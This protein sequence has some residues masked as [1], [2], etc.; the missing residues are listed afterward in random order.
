MSTPL[1]VIVTRPSPY[2]EELCDEL[3]HNDF[4]ST[5]SPLICFNPDIS[6]NSKQRISALEQ[7]DTW[8]FV[9][10]QAVN[11]C[12]DVFSSQQ[13]SSLLQL[14]QS[15]TIIA[16]GDATADS[17][18]RLNFTALTPSTPNSE[19]MIA[20]LEQHQLQT[21]PTLL[22]RGNQGRQL[23]QDYF[24]AQ[25]LT[26]MPVYQRQAT[27]QQL[28]RITESS[29]IVV[30]S[31]Q[32]MEL[33]ANQVSDHSQRIACSIISGSPRISEIAQQFGFTNCYTANNASNDELVKSCI[34]WRNSVS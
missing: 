17:L 8:I 33:V 27:S 6:F 14:S 5:H 23:L 31:G 34:L 16:V 13:M 24:S 30:T 10:R 25:Q 2:G 11:F 9:S 7:A 4:V 1:H 15:K 22:I 26:I 28:P 18:R 20:L 19:G 29:A 3:T 32:L 12:F 21:K